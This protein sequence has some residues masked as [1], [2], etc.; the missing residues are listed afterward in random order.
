MKKLSKVL[1][2]STLALGLVGCGSRESDKTK[3]TF[4]H[5]MNG[6]QEKALEVLVEKFEKENTDIDVV[7][8]N[9]SNYKDLQNKLVST[10]QSP[11]NLPNISQGYAVWFDMAIK[12]NLLLDLTKQVN[13]SEYKKEF[14]DS[15][16][17]NGRLYAVP[18][19]KSTEVLYYNKDIVKELG[20]KIPT[21]FE[22]YE[23]FSKTIL[24]KKGI[25]GG[26][27]DNLANY[28]QTYVMDKENVLINKDWNYSSKTSKEAIEYL[29]NGVD[30]KYFRLAGADKYLSGA[31]SSNKVASFVGTNAG[32]SYV[33]K[34]AKFNWGMTKAPF[35]KSIAQ[36]T[37]L[38]VFN[39]DKKQNEASVKLIEYLT[40]KESQNYW[41]SKTGYIPVSKGSTSSDKVLNEVQ[42]YPTTLDA[43]RNQLY[44]E[45]Y[46]F[47][48][49]ALSGDV[50]KA[51]EYISKKQ[52][53]IFGE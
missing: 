15:D 33:E 5:A 13:Q 43:K 19:A 6:E 17:Y 44:T 21:T 50:D 10:M 3:V 4:W 18:F 29:K 45:G 32:K 24:D 37:D 7:L 8:Q 20:L 49:K 48:E 28:Y 23:K 12:D 11:N 41:A 39:K 16:K 40:S 31:F 34:S 35:N 38:V 22:E 14:I 53:D 30:K 52:K 27:F 2:T 46:V 26:G 36:G 51:I 9:Q 25:A 47:M 42:T 1:L